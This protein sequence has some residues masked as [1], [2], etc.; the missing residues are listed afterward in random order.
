M[1]KQLGV[2]LVGESRDERIYIADGRMEGMNGSKVP[3]PALMDFIL[4]S[5]LHL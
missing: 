4:Q 5:H 1:R 3:E 2:D